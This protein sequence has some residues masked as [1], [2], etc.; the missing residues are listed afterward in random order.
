[1]QRRA[2]LSPGFNA[3]VTAWPG[4]A[5]R[6]SKTRT[7][8]RIIFRDE[9][10]VGRTSRLEGRNGPCSP[11][12]TR[13]DLFVRKPLPK[14]EA[15]AP[16][17]AAARPLGGVESIPSSRRCGMAEGDARVSYHEDED[18]WAVDVEGAAWAA[19]RHDSRERAERAGRALAEGEG[20][21]LIVSGTDGELESTT[22]SEAKED[23]CTSG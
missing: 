23:G 9:V 18:K 3:V 20:G 11:G 19:S 6:F 17:A 10:E 1:M 8:E 2:Q 16:P 7:R 15:G 5:D 4:D 22:G 14:D 21:N 13:G 12:I